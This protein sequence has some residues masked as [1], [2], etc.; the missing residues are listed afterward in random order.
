MA[1]LNYSE[2]LAKRT[3]IMDDDPYV[4]L[5]NSISKKDRQKASNAVKMK[6]L[7]TGNVVDRTF[8]QADVLEE[9]EMEKRELKFLYANKG[10]HWF[11]APENPGDRFSFT[12]ETVGD[13]AQYVSENTVVEA[14]VFNDE[15]IAVKTPIKVQLKVT[16]ASEAVKG[17][18]SSSATKE[19]TLETGL[20]IQ[21]PQFIG[22]G[23]IIAVNT[24]SGNYTERIEKA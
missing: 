21:V 10:E 2:L 4:V 17:N 16:E 9:A 22:Q 15:I 8:H 5:S 20:L 6:N 7:R 23:D 18:T 24:E 14:L 13:L 3:V 11:C 12:D 1:K 19:V